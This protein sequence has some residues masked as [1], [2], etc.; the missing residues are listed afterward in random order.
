MYHLNGTGVV[1]VKKSIPLVTGSHVHKGVERLLKRVMIGEDPSIDHAVGVAVEEYEKEVTD[2]G[3]RGK[4][5]QT[6]RQQEFTFLE[7]R[8]LVEALVRAW[9]IAEMPLIVKRYK[10][11]AVER[12]IEPLPLAPNIEFMAKVDAE[13]QEIETGDYHNY[14]LKTMKQWN[15]R[16]ENS[17]KSDLQGITE[18]WAVEED[19]K[20]ANEILD[21]IASYVAD[22]ELYNSRRDLLKNLNQIEQFARSKIRDKKVM[23]VRFCI[24]I[25]GIRKYP[26]Y[27]STDPNTLMITYSPLIRGYKNIT[28]TS[29]NYAHSWFYPNPENKSGKSALGKGWEPFNVWEQS[30]MNI[31]SW[32]EFL[33]S[34][35]CQSELG[36]IIKAQVVTPVEMF[37]DE[38]EITLGIQ[39]IKQIETH[40]F[41]GLQLLDEGVI[42]KEIIMA[43]Y[44]SHN[45]KMCMFHYGEKC[46]YN[47]LC[48][49]NRVKEDPVASELYEIRTPHHVTEK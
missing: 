35:Q 24:L 36:D 1:A 10:V 27:N 3:F 15:E 43:R 20:R 31:K 41:E 2:K 12:E 45:R 42:D 40:I 37:R 14:S 13:L 48:W 18:I 39:E 46:E 25:K 49:N 9:Y 44:F 22:V 4:G 33:A 23:G 47:D 6:D 26:D 5:V 29:I 21:K 28:P 32:I 7:Q 34:G 11:L 30:D 17:Y 38:E 19:N 16:A 8:A